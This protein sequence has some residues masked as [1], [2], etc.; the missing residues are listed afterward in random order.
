MK[1]SPTTDFRSGSHGRLTSKIR[2]RIQAAAAALA[3][4]GVP[5]ADSLA[6]D[7]SASREVADGLPWQMRTEDGRVNTLVLYANGTGKVTGGPMNLSPKWRATSD[8]L[9]LK[10]AALVKERCVALSPTGKGFVGTR[11][12]ATVFTLER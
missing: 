1:S 10:P 11:D 8:G 9:C 7:D 12:G 2:L 4:L 3:L 6:S 5:V